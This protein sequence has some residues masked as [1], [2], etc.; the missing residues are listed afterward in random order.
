MVAFTKDWHP[1]NHISFAKNHVGH[2][3]FDTIEDHHGVKQVL[4]PV[5]CVQHSKGAEFHPL[6]IHKDSDILIHKGVDP[7][8]DSYSAFWD[9]AKQRQTELKKRLVEKNTSQLYVC[10][11]ALDYCVAYTCLDAVQEGFD[12][13]LILDCSRAISSASLTIKLNELASS[14]VKFTYSSLCNKK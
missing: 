7:N 3:I 6:L 14:G 4:W 9:N 8:I 1:E 10:G 11:L 13:Y 5:H 2:N 12:T